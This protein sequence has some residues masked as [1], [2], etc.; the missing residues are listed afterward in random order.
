MPNN[1]LFRNLLALYTYHEALRIWYRARQEARRLNTR[2]NRQILASVTAAYAFAPST[3]RRSRANSD[4]G[5]AGT[6]GNI[7]SNNM[8]PTSMNTDERRPKYRHLYKTNGTYGGRMKEAKA[9]TVDTAYYKG[10]VLRFETGATF[11]DA[12][13]VY[14]LHGTCP[15]EY[16]MA[17]FARAIVKHIMDKAGYTIVNWNDTPFLGSA[18]N[19]SYRMYYR[20]ANTTTAPVQVNSGNVAL[21]TFIDMATAV[22]D[23]IRASV[24]SSLAIE[25]IRID[26]LEQVAVN[27]TYVRA[28]LDCSNAYINWECAS[29]L[30]FQNSTLATTTVETNN[31]EETNIENNPLI[32]YYYTHK[33][34]NRN[35][36]E[37]TGK[38]LN[39][40]QNNYI[41]HERNGFVAF[42]AATD[43]NLV[44]RKPPQNPQTF[45]LSMASRLKLLPGEIKKNKLQFV[46]RMSLSRFCKIFS[47]GVDTTAGMLDKLDIGKVGLIG[48][49]AML[50]SRLASEPQVSVGFQH[51]LTIKSYIEE[52]GM[53]RTE[54]LIVV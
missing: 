33:T 23:A 13:A 44:L 12:N 36:I 30:T 8:P 40:T 51:D 6:P 17:S 15:Y 21:N 7:S 18:S 20:V 10:S 45:K 49:E 5:I 42:G 47:E 26:L 19:I 31:D 38:M 1:T 28:S 34:K 11:T 32:G 53:K 29:T 16:M 3:P 2:V 25:L 27:N 37:L 41:I 52:G 39:V 54:A 50:N 24:T 35:S 9:R 14:I 46:D 22:M 48:L 4:E 43:N